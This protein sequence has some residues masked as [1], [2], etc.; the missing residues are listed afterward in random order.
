M[1]ARLLDTAPNLLASINGDRAHAFFFL[2]RFLLSVHWRVGL[3]LLIFGAS[4][5][6]HGF[7]KIRRLFR[8]AWGCSRCAE[9]MTTACVWRSEGLMLRVCL[10]V[11]RAW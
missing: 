11:C 7:G 4:V 10:V 5:P 8:G 2:L 1:L 9:V 6:L 3:G